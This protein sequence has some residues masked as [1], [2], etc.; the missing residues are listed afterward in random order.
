VSSRFRE[1][2]R[3][4]HQGTAESNRGRHLI[5]LLGIHE[6]VYMLSLS[7]SLSLSL[8]HTHTHTHTHRAHTH[9]HRHTHTYTQ[10]HIHTHVEQTQ[11]KPFIGSNVNV[12]KMFKDTITDPAI[13]VAP[14]FG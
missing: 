6:H 5:A 14:V 10:A 11:E 13:T 9:T 4:W 2:V 7:L 3:Y 12:L 8:T 1:I